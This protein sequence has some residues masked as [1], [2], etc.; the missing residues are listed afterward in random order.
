MGDKATC[1]TH[2]NAVVR[3]VKLNGGIERIVGMNGFLRQMVSVFA[4]KEQLREI[5]ADSGV[6]N[7]PLST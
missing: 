6:A 5:S 1:K 2:M 3:M 7:N 4:C